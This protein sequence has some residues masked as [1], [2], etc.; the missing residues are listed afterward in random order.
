MTRYSR[1][2]QNHPTAKLAS[3]TYSANTSTGVIREH[4][5]HHRESHE[6]WCLKNSQPNRTKRGKEE[7]KAKEEATGKVVRPSQARPKFTEEKFKEALVTF[8]VEDDQVSDAPARRI[9]VTESHLRA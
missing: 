6:H 5:K 9:S 8:I 7:A 3:Y 4:L 1:V 2:A